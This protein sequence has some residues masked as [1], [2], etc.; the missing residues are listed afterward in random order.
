MTVT[1]VRT[2]LSFYY[3][4]LWIYG[5][6]RFIDLTLRDFLFITYIVP[7]KG[8]PSNRQEIP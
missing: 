4:S 1:G 7:S 5:R 3:E 8:K 6:I 2:T